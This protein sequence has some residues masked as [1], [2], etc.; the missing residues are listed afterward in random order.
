VNVGLAEDE[1][2]LQQQF[3]A[4]SNYVRPGVL[5]GSDDA[6]VERINQYV[7]AG[8]TQVNIALRAPFQLDPLRRF[9]TALGLR[10]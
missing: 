9:A 1:A 8:A 7:A 3:G 4:L 10:G 2:S 5:A 6:I